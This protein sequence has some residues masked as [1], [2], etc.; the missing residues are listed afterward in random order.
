MTP[1]TL[2]VRPVLYV[3]GDPWAH[4]S[5]FSFS[6][7][8]LLGVPFVISVLSCR[9][10]QR[11]SFFLVVLCDRFGAT[12]RPCLAIPSALVPFS[13]RPCLLLADPFGEPVLCCLAP[14]V[15]VLLSFDGSLCC[16]GLVVVVVDDHCKKQIALLLMSF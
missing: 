5:F 13:A 2:G 14:S 3:L 9:H 7:W 6:R 16:R 1:W 8:Y 11:T 4:S 12:V 10:T 15:H